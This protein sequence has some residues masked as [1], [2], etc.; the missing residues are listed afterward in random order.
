MLFCTDIV[1]T[2]IFV[3]SQTPGCSICYWSNAVETAGG[4][5]DFYPSMKF[6][7]PRCVIVKHKSIV[8]RDGGLSN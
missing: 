2:L 8:A 3:A 1:S 4:E 7:R 6:W 5:F